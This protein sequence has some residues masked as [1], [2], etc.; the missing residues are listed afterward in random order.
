[1]N[2]R[3]RGGQREN[4]AKSIGR[5]HS[6][7]VWRLLLAFRS[8]RFFSSFFSSRP[9]VNGS[10][11]SSFLFLPLRPACLPLLRRS[12]PTSSSAPSSSRVRTEIFVGFGGGL[13]RVLRHF[14]LG[15]S[16]GGIGGRRL[17]V[18][19]MS[20]S[21]DRGIPWLGRAFWPAGA[22]PVCATFGFGPLPLLISR[23]SCRGR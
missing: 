16:H 11:A 22:A 5:Q 14:V 18:A 7:A 23:K 1:V 10:V 20:S 9:S 19:K 21:L 12:S 17:F 15:A 8:S 6:S 2:H 3:R 4:A 13:V